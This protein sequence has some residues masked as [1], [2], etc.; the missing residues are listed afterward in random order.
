MGSE[1]KAAW[2][3]VVVHAAFTLITAW[4]GAEAV[5]WIW[6]KLRTPEAVTTKAT[7]FNARVPAPYVMFHAQPSAS[8]DHDQG[9]G[10]RGEPSFVETNSQGFRAE[11]IPLIKPAGEK[12]VFV[13]GGSALFYGLRNDTTI[14][15]YLERS[16][17]ENSQGTVFKVFNASIESGDSDQE[18]SILVH[19]IADL[20]PDIV[21]VFDGFNDIWTRLHYEPRLGHPFNWPKFENAYG[22]NQMIRKSLDQLNPL[23]HLLAMSKVA[24]RINP[25]WKLENRIIR[26]FHET[27]QPAASAPSLNAEFVHKAAVRLMV[28]WL[29]MYR[30]TNAIDA[31]MIGILQPISPDVPAEQ[32]V[33]RFY[34][35]VNK[36][37]ELLRPQG[38]PFF[39]FDNALDVHPEYFRDIVHTWDDA[40]PF[41]AQL[42][43]D[44]LTAE[45]FLADDS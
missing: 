30:F 36:Q 45:G 39:S 18:L 6:D 31:K 23:D 15:G 17:N 24:T 12:R 34:E 3:S 41:Y 21:L 20:S 13:L 8:G 14:T 44:L 28:N 1:S 9:Q 10:R 42:I 29:K 2:K 35:L 11:E 26:S 4:I 33:A 38:Y 5:L 7:E 19:Q 22:N 32:P 25:S 43:Q 27:V 40:H 16:L 37:I